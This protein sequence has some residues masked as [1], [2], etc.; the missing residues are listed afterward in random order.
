MNLKEELERA[1]L[2][3]LNRLQGLI[4]TDTVYTGDKLVVE[5]DGFNNFTGFSTKSAQWHALSV[6]Q[7]LGMRLP[8]DIHGTR[9]GEQERSTLIKAYLIEYEFLATKRRVQQKRGQLQAR[10]RGVYTGRK[11]I[12]VS[13]PLP[14]EVRQKLKA[15]RITLDEALAIT[16]LS[17][18]TLYRKFKQLEESQ[19]RKV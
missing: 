15:G 4:N 6:L 10:E 14:D 1:N 16:K 12:E 13:L 19:N 17:K 18:A 5:Q 8:I 11:P 7:L 3:Y 9:F 2:D